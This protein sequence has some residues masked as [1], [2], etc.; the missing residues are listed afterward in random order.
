MGRSC[1]MRKEGIG[2]HGFRTIFSVFL[3]ILSVVGGL[4]SLYACIKRDKKRE[5]MRDG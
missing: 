1:F 2:G 3:P 5:K 4:E